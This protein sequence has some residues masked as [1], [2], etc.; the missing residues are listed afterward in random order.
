MI[1]GAESRIGSAKILKN[2]IAYYKV[3]EVFSQLTS[4]ERKAGR[5]LGGF[6][7]QEEQMVSRGN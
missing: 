6:S 3:Q 7:V 2:T 5:E 4:R 1:G